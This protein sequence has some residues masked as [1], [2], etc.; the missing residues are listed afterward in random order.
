MQ[1]VFLIIQF[2]E[3]FNLKT[4]VRALRLLYSAH[5]LS[6]KMKLK[7]E[8]AVMHI[9]YQR[10]TLSY[11]QLASGRVLCTSLPWLVTVISRLVA[12]AQLEAEE[13]LCESCSHRIEKFHQNGI[14]LVI[15]HLNDPY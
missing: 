12:D 6:F 14:V 3:S 2:P 7:Q 8:V 5:S 13:M 4:L 10:E 9:L 15:S 11:S 1:L